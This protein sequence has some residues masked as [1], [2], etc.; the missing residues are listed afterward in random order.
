MLWL[1]LLFATAP[2]ATSCR[3]SK[4]P[5]NADG[6]DTVRLKYA[7]N[8][9]IVRYKDHTIVRLLN[10]WRKGEALATYL[11]FEKGQKPTSE[12][13]QEA[14][15]VQIP[16]QKSVVSTAPHCQLLE[17]LGASEAIKGLCDAQYIRTPLTLKSF[18]EGNI[19]D[20]GSSMTPNIECI[21]GLES[22]AILVSPYENSSYGKLEKTG[23]PI[24]A[25][26]D[27]MEPTALGRAEWMKFY[28]LLYGQEQ[29]AD[30]LFAAVESSYMKLKKQAQTSRQRPRI[31][32]ERKTGSVW[33]CPGGKSSQAAL[34]ADAN[35]QYVFAHDDHSGSLC[36]SP[37][38]VVEKAA[39]CDL[40]LFV[41]Y[42]GEP[43]SAEA[44][45]AEYKGYAQLKAL[46]QGN[47]YECNSAESNY[48]EEI[49]FRP[50][51]LLEQLI[52]I[53]HPDIATKKPLRYYRKM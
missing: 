13:A 27:Y 12:D 32:T 11:L 8:L 44:I 16:L 24:I 10:P 48:F 45:A 47:V 30:S 23:I 40:W 5:A 17:W 29:R 19:V 7:Q 2:L 21:I 31:I 53:A 39:D 46:R 9:T 50:D 6:G 35:L 18:S 36:L 33:Y 37:E 34:F 26:A 15:A 1:M 49:S 42:G 3:Q 14:T 38:T 28:G 51:F 43:L 52:S 25:C 41:Y 4:S 20:C 22:D